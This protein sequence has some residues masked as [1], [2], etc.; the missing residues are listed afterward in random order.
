MATSLNCSGPI[1]ASTS[2]PES[3]S[4]AGMR[5]STP[6]VCAEVPASCSG[7]KH[8]HAP[9]PL[10]LGQRSFFYTPDT[11]DLYTHQT[12]AGAITRPHHSTTYVDVGAAYCYRPS[13]IVSQSVGHDRELCKS[14]WTDQEAVW[15]WTRVGPR[16]THPLKWKLA[17][18]GQMKQSSRDWLSIKMCFW[19]KMILVATPQAKAW[20]CLRCSIFRHMHSDEW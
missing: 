14:S 7:D 4:I 2:R 15:L 9:L 17:T 12:P 3:P 8:E 16:K 18:C 10:Q 13:S 19:P 20:R 6:A 11:P 1:A 5:W